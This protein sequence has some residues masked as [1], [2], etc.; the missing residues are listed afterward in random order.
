MVNLVIYLSGIVLVTLLG[1]KGFDALRAWRYKRSKAR[2]EA[3]HMALQAAYA[4]AMGDYYRSL[5]YA[6]TRVTYRITSDRPEQRG[7]YRGWTVEEICAELE[8]RA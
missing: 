1:L 2:Q 8:R 3:A 4:R 7:Y 6:E 5:E